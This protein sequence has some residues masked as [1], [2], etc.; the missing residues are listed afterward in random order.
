MKQ[1]KEEK[2]VQTAAR[3]LHRARAW[4]LVELERRILSHV[5]KKRLNQ[6]LE[7][8]R[9]ITEE[10]E[11]MGVV[12]VRGMTGEY[13]ASLHPRCVKK[14]GDVLARYIGDETTALQV[15]LEIN[16]VPRGFTMAQHHISMA[17][18]QEV[19]GGVLVEN[20]VWVDEVEDEGEE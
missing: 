20:D 15:G 9:K 14:A 8:Q 7:E 17:A 11:L 2:L 19:M 13:T 16:G 3:V 5:P 4:W 10:F 12:P 1:T 18:A 6:L